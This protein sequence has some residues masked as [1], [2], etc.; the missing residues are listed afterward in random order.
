MPSALYKTLDRGT[1]TTSTEDLLDPTNEGYKPADD[2]FDT[3]GATQ[4][5]SSNTPATH[6]DI[7]HNILRI[8]DNRYKTLGGFAA[9]VQWCLVLGW[10]ECMRLSAWFWK[11]S[12]TAEVCS[13]MLAIFSLVTLV[14]TLLTHQDKPLPEWPQLITINSIVSLIALFMRI[15]VSV[16]LGE[17][18]NT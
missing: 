17:G 16:V 2:S 15:G 18:K 4:F 9:Y 6:P 3:D 1:A 14:L 12:W 5:P 8:W 13:F 11:K 10:K 7:D